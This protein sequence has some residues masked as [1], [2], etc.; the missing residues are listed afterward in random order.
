MSDWSECIVSGGSERISGHRE[1]REVIVHGCRFVPGFDPLQ[2]QRHGQIR[3]QG[4]F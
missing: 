3:I 1:K 2:G 4:P